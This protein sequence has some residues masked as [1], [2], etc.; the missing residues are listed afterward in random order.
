MAALVLRKKTV[1]YIVAQSAISVACIV[2]TLW[3]VC[4]HQAVLPGVF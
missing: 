3:S 2:V 4:L 1:P